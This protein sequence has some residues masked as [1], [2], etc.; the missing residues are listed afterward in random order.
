MAAARGSTKG[1]P[2]SERPPNELRRKLPKGKTPLDDLAEMVTEGV[3]SNSLAVR[4]WTEG[5]VP[6]EQLGI[7][8]LYVALEGFG[9]AVRGRQEVRRA[10]PLVCN[11]TELDAFRPG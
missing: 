9:A 8:E 5:I 6:A 11:D 10:L 2:A 7:T 4:E 1:K 3:A